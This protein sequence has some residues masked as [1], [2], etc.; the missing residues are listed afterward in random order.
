M[1]ND[2]KRLA[3]LA[4]LFFSKVQIN[5]KLFLQ[6]CLHLYSTRHRVA[7]VIIIIIIIKFVPFFY[8]FGVFLFCL[9]GPHQ[10]KSTE[11]III[12]IIIIIIVIIKL[13]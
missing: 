12:I 9:L 3:F 6:I 8:F 11:I 4:T 2:F 10:L 7:L 5:T 1:W 13:I